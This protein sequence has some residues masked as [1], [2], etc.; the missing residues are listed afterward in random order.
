MPVGRHLKKIQDNLHCLKKRIK[1]GNEPEQF[2]IKDSIIIKS[3]K[4]NGY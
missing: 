1:K 4:D 3:K 2:S